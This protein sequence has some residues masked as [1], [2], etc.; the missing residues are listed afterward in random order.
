MGKIIDYFIERSLFVNLLSILILIIGGWIILNMNRE[1]FPNIDYDIIT[2]TTVWPGASS[3]EIEK[4][5]TNPLEESIKEVDGIKE[6][7]SSSIESRS[8][9]TITVDP[10]MDD[11]ENIINEIRS[12]VDRADDLPNNAETPI[13][14]EVT[15]SR[16]PVIEWALIRRETKDKRHTI[17]YREL[18]DI[19]ESL[20]NRFLQIKG[21]AR[22][23]RRGWRDAE[24]FVDMDPKRMRNFLVGGNDVVSALRQR[25]VN[26]PGGDILLPHEEI[27]VR[28]IG[29]FNTAKEIAQ[30]P[31]RANEVGASVKVKDIANV[32][33]DFQESD[34]IELAENSESISLT[35]TKRESADIINVVDATQ[36]VVKQ[37]QATL[38]KSIKVVA[39]N[40]L[41]YLAKRR[42]GVLS[43]NGFIGLFLVVGV[44]FFFFG[45]RTAIVVAVGIPISFGIAFI[46]MSYTNTTLNLISMFGLIIV[47]GI[48]VDDAII[49]SENFYRY[50][51]E[52]MPAKESASRGA[53]EVFSPILA[54]VS[55]TIAAFAPMLFMSGIFGKFVFIIPFVVIIA[56]LGSFIECFFILPSHLYDMNRNSKATIAKKSVKTDNWFIKFRTN[57]YQP[58]L[59]FSLKNKKTCLGLLVATLVFCLILQILLGSFRL[60]PGS[61]DRI[62]IKVETPTGTRKELTQR[63]LQAIGSYVGKLPKSEL[64]SFTARA[65]IQSKDPNDP[66]TKRGSHYGTLT[67]HLHPYRKLSSEKVIE[68]L[69]QQTMWLTKSNKDQTNQASPD[70]VAKPAI[71]PQYHDLK[72]GLVS[73]EF[74]KMQGGPP[75]GKPISIQII[76]K[77]LQV[78]QKISQEYKKILGTI[79]GVIGIGDSFLP[80]KEEIRVKVNENIAAQAKVSVLDVAT[81]INTGFEGSVAT[82][83]RRPN[84]EVDVR[85]RFAKEYRNSLDALKEVS[86]TN[87]Q[88]NLIPVLPLTSFKREKSIT[89]LNHLDGRRL[90]TV[91]S[92]VDTETLSSTEAIK[93]VK[94]LSQDIPNRYPKYTIQYGGEYKDT[95]ESL[96]GLKRSF[97]VS[98]TIIFLILA[99]LFGSLLQPFVILS[100]VPFALIGV[101]IAFLSHGEPFSFMAFFG[102]IGLTGVVINDSIVL[103]DLANRIK[104]ANPGMSNSEVAYMAGSQRL[105]PILLT[106]LTTVGGLLP[107]AYGLGGYD[108]FLV[109]MALAFAWGLTFSTVLIIIGI[110]ILYVLVEDFTDWRKRKFSSYF[111]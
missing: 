55:T 22:V 48:I 64:I 26:L 63:F 52:G 103:V 58:C 90:L 1:T 89:A 93:K 111:A 66:F 51:E 110:P 17:S 37:F 23:S 73:L 38:P 82:S 40:D 31:V 5:V 7:R 108:P 84:E 69:Q 109:P 91:S 9:I 2:I 10:D 21:V 53:L 68:Q 3:Q 88:G 62:Q 6:Y 29:E 60:F 106:S 98:I 86:L 46:V 39:V 92:D 76:G 105:R 97:L 75:V 61:V 34:Y 47:I 83:I 54:S 12:A 79:A 36:K 74:E 101:I 80:G 14:R 27:I 32:Y 11:T 49:V 100:A 41:S 81:A 72:G 87:K 44:L 78:L 43:S 96:D 104:K 70:T 102:I 67:I 85:V 13:V 33:E 99:S 4:L 30:V 20:E 45:W 94:Q 8:N 42:L 59:R 95:G 24:I 65:G 50:F 16:L 35:V 71:T 77:D 57:F 28:T 19:A 56:L 25:N 18:R 15:S 107:T